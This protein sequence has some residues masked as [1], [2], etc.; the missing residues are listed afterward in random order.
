MGRVR[1]T[2]PLGYNIGEPEIP[3]PLPRII[4]WGEEFFLADEEDAIE[5]VENPR[6]RQTSGFVIS[7]TKETGSGVYKLPRRSG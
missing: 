6:Y 5:D 2:D 1:L 4:V 7:D 3:E